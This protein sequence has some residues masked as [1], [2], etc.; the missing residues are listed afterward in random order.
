MWIEKLAQGVLCV[1]TPLGPRYIQLSFWERVYLLWIFR[2]FQTLPPQVLHPRQQQFIDG[3]CKNDRFVSNSFQNGVVDFP[4]VGTL[5]RRPVIEQLPSRP[6]STR[7]AETV[8]QLADGK[9]G[10]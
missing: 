8:V 7:V 9:Q 6:P 2:N 3:V 5:E 1:Q 4:I 10:S